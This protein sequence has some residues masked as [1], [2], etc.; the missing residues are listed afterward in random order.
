MKFLRYFCLF[1]L[2]I[3]LHFSAKA[4]FIDSLRTS[5]H[6][7]PSFFF[8]FDSHTS[9]INS[10]QAN[11]WGFVFGV[12]F[13][14]KINIGGGFNTLSTPFF[15][16]KTI[17]TEA[18]S[19][20]TI[21]ESLSFAYWTY[22]LEYIFYNTKH[23]QFSVPFEIGLGSSSYQYVYKG[24]TYSDSPHLIIPIEPSFSITYQ[25]D[26]W[27]GFGTEIGYRFMLVNNNGIKG[28]FNSPTYNLGL[29]IYVIEV[30]KSLFPHSKITKKLNSLS[31]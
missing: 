10:D 19:D 18:K 29:Q 2:L 11:I 20:S 22:Y 17:T 4:Q 15:K 24:I 30:F 1:F 7:K 23:W 21:N 26:K 25:F 5:I 8:S 27:I 13:N 9:F 16:N 6:T 12:D 31:D 14:N 3:T 28:N